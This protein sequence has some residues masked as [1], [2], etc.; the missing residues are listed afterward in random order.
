MFVN[1]KSILAPLVFVFVSLLLVFVIALSSFLSLFQSSF[2]L[3]LL[4]VWGHPKSLR[5]VV[6]SWTEI[7]QMQAVIYIPAGEIWVLS[8]GLLYP[9]IFF[10][11]T[12]P[13][14]LSTHSCL[15]V[16][17]CSQVLS[18]H[19]GTLKE[20]FD[21]TLSNFSY[22][23]CTCIRLWFYVHNYPIDSNNKNLKMCEYIGS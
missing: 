15:G 9:L 19:T 3:G 8:K 10:H 21:Y 5:I 6:T 7:C 11:M 2:L 4:I 1:R 14:D 12:L 22:C 18:Y 17:L 20:E 13:A 16:S 23:V